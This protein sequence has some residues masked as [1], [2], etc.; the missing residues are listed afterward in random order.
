MNIQFTNM[1]QGFQNIIQICREHPECNGCP[2]IRG[3]PISGND[4]L[5]YLCETGR[6]KEGNSNSEGQENGGK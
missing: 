5:A 4:G 2:Y 6:N 3:S 1:N